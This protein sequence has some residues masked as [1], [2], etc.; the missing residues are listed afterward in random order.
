MKLAS[1]LTNTFLV[2][3]FIL[4]FITGC[5]K[6]D[7]QPLNTAQ[8][9]TVQVSEN[10]EISLSK[11]G[12]TTTFVLRPAPKT[13]QD[14]YVCQ[15]NGTDLGNENGVDELAINAWTDEGLPFNCSAYIRFDSL[16]IIP[17]SSVVKRARLY[18]YTPS[19]SRSTPQ[20][21][22]GDNACYVRG[23]TQPWY[24][25]SL[26]YNNQ[27]ADTN[28][29]QA[30]LTP[31]YSQWN[32]TAVVDVTSLVTYFVKHP[33]KSFGFHITLVEQAIYRSYIFGSSEQPERQYRPKIVVIYQ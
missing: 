30:I 2:A 11:E 14:V 1:Q 26:S 25:S 16:A 32:D 21:N 12:N 15:W 3:F 29:Y 23:V 20:G 5:K 17:K 13:S 22:S 10:D 7:V 8:V 9:N 31:S 19:S 27:P 18:L 33:N 4:L 24:E 28:L 6:T